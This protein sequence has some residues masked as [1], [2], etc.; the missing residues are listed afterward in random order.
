MSIKLCLSTLKKY[1]ENFIYDGYDFKAA[2]NK[3]RN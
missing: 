2:K 1:V 3:K